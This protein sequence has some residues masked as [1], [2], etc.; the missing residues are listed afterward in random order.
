MIRDPYQED[1]LKDLVAR[2]SGLQGA[3][4]ILHAMTGTLIF[5]A[6]TLLEL[7]KS[8]TV[9]ALLGV[10]FVLL[11]SDLI[12]LRVPRFNV[13][14]FRFFKVLVSPRESD[15]VASSTWYIL[16]GLIAIAV[17]RLPA[18]LSGIL[19]LAWADPTAS[20]LGRRWGKRP[21]LG[22]TLE[23]S[24]AF[25]A[26][27]TL[28]LLLRHPPAVAIASACLMTLAE[29]VAWPF[30]D[31]LMLAPACAGTLTLLEWIV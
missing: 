20:Y 17:F 30:D 16:G 9:A 31:N 19:V 7:S 10:F 22:G 13:L 4:R 27:A 6:I 11:A 1:D 2:T 3:R 21:F 24:T 15:H 26:V 18:A 12:R 29:R 28:I 25:L 8:F 5:L 23:G 14:F